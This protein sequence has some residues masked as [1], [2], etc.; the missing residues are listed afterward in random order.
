[1]RRPRATVYP[2]APVLPQNL[3]RMHVFFSEPPFVDTLMQAVRLLDNHDGVVAHPFLDLQ[4]GLWDAT[5]TR[6]T[7]LLHPG[8]IKSGLA[9][10]LSRGPAIE[11]SQR[12]R[13]AIDMDLLFG[14]SVSETRWHSH[15]FS[16]GPAIE[17]AVDHAAWNI[18][19]PLPGSLDPLRLS[20]GRSMDRLGLEGAFAV[21]AA[22]GSSVPFTQQVS[23]AEQGVELTPQQ[24]WR[25]EVHRLDVAAGLEDVAGNRVAQAFEITRDAAALS[26]SAIAAAPRT[27]IAVSIGTMQRK[28]KPRLA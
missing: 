23:E 9:S 7:L 28:I 25:P 18:G 6:L 16:I 1:M 21:T 24:A 8:R 26:I 20:F 13:L 15:A 4:E 27:H 5:G 19:R 22:D 17:A 2:S 3:L 12:Y 11:Q 10:R 14:P